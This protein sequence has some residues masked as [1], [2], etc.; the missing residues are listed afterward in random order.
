MVADTA[1]KV[2]P[3]VPPLSAATRAALA[4]ILPPRSGIGNPVD[5]AGV[6]EEE[7]E[8]VPRVVDIALGDPAIGGAPLP[9]PLGGAAEEATRE[10]APGEAGGAA[11]RAPGRVGRGGRG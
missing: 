6:A 5:F 2:A 7:P 10:P 11:R 3:A 9:G 4:A 1:D 8:V